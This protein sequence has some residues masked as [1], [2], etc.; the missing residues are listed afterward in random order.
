MGTLIIRLPDDQH[1]RLKV[2][3]SQRGLSL[4]KLFEEFLVSCVFV[5]DAL[6]HCVKCF[7]RAG[8]EVLQGG[9]A[10]AGVNGELSSV[11]RRVEGPVAGNTGRPGL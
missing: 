11:G 1:E 10:E 3:A 6:N 8:G 7:A 4:N 9:R 5:S 2:L